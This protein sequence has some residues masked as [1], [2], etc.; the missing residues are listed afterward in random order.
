MG[1]QYVCGD[2]HRRGHTITKSDE[3]YVDVKVF[4]HGAYHANK[5]CYYVQHQPQESG[6]MAYQLLYFTRKL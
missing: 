6:L 4:T 5:H 2:V 3:Q 1:Y